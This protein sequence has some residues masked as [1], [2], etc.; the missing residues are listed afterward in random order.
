[1]LRSATWVFA[2]LSLSATLWAKAPT[3]LIEING[4]SLTSPI[5]ITS[6]EALQKYTFLDGPGVSTWGG[7]YA[8]G[9]IVDWKSGSVAQPPARRQHYQA[10]FYW[11]ARTRP[12]SGCYSDK[13]C[14]AYVAFYDYDPISKRGFV[15]LPGKGEQWHD[16]DINVVYHQVEGKWF[17]ATESWNSFLRTL[18]ANKSGR[19][20]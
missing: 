18:I 17:R 9:S 14:L 8:S 11:P 3:I 16:L 13:P 6:P 4:S 12:Q 5:E 7:G 20:Q 10:S 19:S 15:Y 2:S 1:M